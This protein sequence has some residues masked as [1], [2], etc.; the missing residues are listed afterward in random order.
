MRPREPLFDRFVKYVSKSVPFGTY[1]LYQ[2]QHEK[3]AISFPLI[4]LKSLHPWFRL[5]LSNN[6][7]LLLSVLLLYRT[8]TNLLFES[9]RKFTKCQF[10][11]TGGFYITPSHCRSSAGLHNALRF[12]SYHNLIKEKRGGRDILNATIGNS[13]CL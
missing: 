9:C 13:K 1:M 5:S 4:S 8:K 2:K 12:N 3:A 11:N 6:I 10:V 7:S